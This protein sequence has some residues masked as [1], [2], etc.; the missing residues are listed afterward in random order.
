MDKI[1]LIA[2]PCSA[3]TR[4]QMMKTAT[5]LRAVGIRTLR[6]GLWKPRSHYGTFEGVGEKGLAW[7]EEI[8]QTLGMRVMTEVALPSHVEAALNAGL[9][10]LWIGART[11]V[12]PF[13][14]HELAE[15]LRGTDI[16]IWVK[17]PVS[18]D[19]ELWIGAIERLQHAGVKRIGAIHRGFCLVDNAPYRNSPLWDQIKELRNRVPGIPVYCDPS[20]IAG[21]REL[22][23]QICQEAL[24]LKVDGL[25]IESH[26]CPQEALSDAAQQLPPA[27]LSDM[28]HTLNID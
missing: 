14:M 19:L 13:M 6:A 4:E 5:Q 23:L 11:T 8:Q 16:P 20:H 2:G 22:L 21:K 7:M 18:P 12:N 10:M 28:L 26:C 17:N 9:D 27:A 3:E 25:F 15:A 1:E 24:S